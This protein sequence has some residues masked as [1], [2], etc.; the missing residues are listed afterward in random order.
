MVST[1]IDIDLR[2]LY[3]RLP[4]ECRKI[5][6]QYIKEKMDEALIEQLILGQQE[7]KKE[8]RGEKK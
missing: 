6:I 8:E 3:K 1:R 2:E 5:V 4:P 7:E